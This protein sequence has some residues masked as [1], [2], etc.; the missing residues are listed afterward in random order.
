MKMPEVRCSV[1]NCEYWATDN[2]CKAAS[3]MIDI[4]HHANA[5]YTDEFAADPGSISLEHKDHASNVQ[6]TCCHT[7]KSK[8]K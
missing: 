3:I 8:K 7:F 2:K 5:D 1:A 6:S 4:D